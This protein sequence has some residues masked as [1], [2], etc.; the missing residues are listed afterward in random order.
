MSIMPPT[1]TCEQHTGTCHGC[2]DIERQSNDI[3][4]EC[5][6]P[7][8]C[9][10]NQL[11]MIEKENNN[12]KCKICRYEMINCN[13]PEIDRKTKDD[14]I[15]TMLRN[16][17]KLSFKELGKE[18]G[19]MVAEKQLAYGD[20]FGKSEQILKVLFPDGVKPDQYTDILTVARIVDKLFRIATDKDALGENP[21]Q[22]IAGYGLLGTMKDRKDKNER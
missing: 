11:T 12:S 3:K 9:V 10:C 19:K 4:K 13:C 21:Y 1:C 5:S 17:T 16:K 22:D 14:I 8:V 20:S 7:D 6:C 18:I 15:D 2:E